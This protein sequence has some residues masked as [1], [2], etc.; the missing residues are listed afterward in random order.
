MSGYNANFRNTG[1]TL[2]GLTLDPGHAVAGGILPVIPFFP[3]ILNLD[4]GG[5]VSGDITSICAHSVFRTVDIITNQRYFARTVTFRADKVGNYTISV[6]ADFSYF[7]TAS[8][9][10]EHIWFSV[11]SDLTFTIDD[12]TTGPMTLEVTTVDPNVFGSFEV[13][14]ACPILDVY[15]TFDH[16]GAEVF[17]QFVQLDEVQAEPLV[18][19]FFD[20][21]TPYV[22]NP[23]TG[24]LYGDGMS[25]KTL[26]GP[27]N[28]GWATSF[29]P[30][31][32]FTGTGWSL[33]FWFKVE[34]W[35]DFNLFGGGPIVEL[36]VGS[37]NV[38]DSSC[39]IDIGF[40]AFGAFPV[41]VTPIP[42]RVSFFINDSVG[43]DTIAPASFAPT[44]GQWNMLHVF[45]KQA[46]GGTFGYSL[47]NGAEVTVT[48]IQ[49]DTG[50]SSLFAFFQ[51]WSG[52]SIDA[53]WLR[54]DEV[55]IRM[56]DVLSPADITYLYNSGAGRTWP[57][58]LP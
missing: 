8:R 25:W 13:T 28:P 58:A 53:I 27:F 1:V 39:L 26:T 4:C 15:W 41:G 33:V 3:P 5:N 55:A 22:V 6:T 44:L 10:A 52:T 37:D 9:D 34:F 48:G 29:T 43:T 31:L 36:D 16:P 23:T 24:G 21:Q 47:N 46:G 19:T 32:A 30:T 57:L 20:F 40:N 2:Q 42:N 17:S 14:L 45:Y 38:L 56:S 54:I 11:D 51:T 50:P 7:I 12:K 18:S 49:C 35:P